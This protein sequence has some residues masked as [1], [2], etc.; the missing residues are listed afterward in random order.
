MSGL[1]RVSCDGEAPED[2]LPSR[3]GERDHQQDGLPSR[4]GEQSSKTINHTVAKHYRIA[5]AYIREHQLDGT[6]DCE[7]IDSEDNEAD[8]LTKAQTPRLFSA[9]AAKVMGPQPDRPAK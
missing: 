1:G 2:G 3:C 7:K 8:M 9:H 5:Q 4:C 6:I